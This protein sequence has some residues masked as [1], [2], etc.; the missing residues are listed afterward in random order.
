MVDLAA[1]N[2]VACYFIYYCYCNVSK[3]KV[4]YCYNNNII[5]VINTVR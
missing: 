5:V 1:C 3:V 2:T 4:T